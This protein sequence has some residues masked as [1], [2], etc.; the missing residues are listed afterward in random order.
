MRATSYLS[1]PSPPRHTHIDAPPD[2]VHYFSFFLSPLLQ[3]SC[4]VFEIKPH[5]AT[6]TL[7]QETV[8]VLYS[9]LKGYYFCIVCSMCTLGIHTDIR[10]LRLTVSC[11][12]LQPSQGKGYRCDD[13]Y[14]SNSTNTT[15]FLQT[16]Q[17]DIFSIA[18]RV[19]A[20]ISLGCV[21]PLTCWET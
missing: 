14:A 18:V 17:S 2:Q 12:N 8:I 20:I 5:R 9:N 7:I 3:D 4:H 6:L 19:I 15:N 11:V 21:S 1:A 16:F 10:S 13:D